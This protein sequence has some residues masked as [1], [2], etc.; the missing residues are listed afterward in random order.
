[1]PCLHPCFRPT[2][3]GV[4][5]GLGAGCSLVMDADFDKYEARVDGS[6]GASGA[7]GAGGAGSAGAGGTGG[8]EPVLLLNEIQTAGSNGPDDE[9]IEIF[10]A[11]DCPAQLDQ[12]KLAY[13]SSAATT[14]HGV[15]WSGA[16]GQR[17]EP[18]HLFIVA[19]PGFPGPAG[20]IFPSGMALG[21]NG[22][23]LAIRRADESILDQVGWGDADNGFIDITA[24]PAPAQDQAIGRI[25]D[26]QDTDDNATDFVIVTP[27]P[28]LANAL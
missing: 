15:S 16:P 25:P 17:I 18:W 9:F 23:G 21:A 26:G 20:A 27:T 24:A 6:A 19:G 14:D 28:G 5:L 13:R 7:G 12:Y 1:M 4:L 22:G 8:C 10:N 11:S 2:V 3:L